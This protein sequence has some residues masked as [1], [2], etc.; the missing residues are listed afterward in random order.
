MNYDQKAD[1]LDQLS[2]LYAQQAEIYSNWQPNRQGE[3]DQAKR[4]IKALEA[5]YSR[6][7]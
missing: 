2:H 6:L 4:E 1:I 7:K 3:L 5:Q